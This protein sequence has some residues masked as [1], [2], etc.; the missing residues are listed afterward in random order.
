LRSALVRER[1]MF[2]QAPLWVRAVAPKAVSSLG[3]Q[4]TFVLQEDAESLASS[5]GGLGRGIDAC[6]KKA[7]MLSQTLRAGSQSPQ[8]VEG[9]VLQWGMKLCRAGPGARL[10]RAQQHY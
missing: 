9:P 7:D 2:S 8:C 3:L 1:H 4:V 5:L 10:V 6:C